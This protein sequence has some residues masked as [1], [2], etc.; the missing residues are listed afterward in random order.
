[1][2]RRQAFTLLEMMAVM[3][4]LAILL[5]ISAVTLAGLMRIQQANA[6][7]HERLVQRSA[8]ADQ[9]RADVARAADAPAS[10]D[11]LKAGPD[12]LILRLADGK[13]VV[14]RW[15]GDQLERTELAG[16]GEN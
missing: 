8:L 5:G 13:H 4:G 3:W 9:F 2:L 15:K 11:K 14:Y 6:Q 16:P 1:P 10:L 12:C 7:T